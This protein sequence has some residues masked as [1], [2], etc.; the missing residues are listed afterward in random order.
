[1]HGVP[2]IR[3]WLVWS[4]ESA[5][6][7]FCFYE[8]QQS[9]VR[10]SRSPHGQRIVHEIWP[11]LRECELL[12]LRNR[13][14]FRLCARL[15]VVRSRLPEMPDLRLLLNPSGSPAAITRPSVVKTRQLCPWAT[16]HPEFRPFSFVEVCGFDD[17]CADPS[18]IVLQG[19]DVDCSQ[20]DED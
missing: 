4:S 7:T 10:E 20:H 13:W 8:D 15:R 12:L 17:H 11:D 6:E 14:K 3:R 19:P 9:H 16:L 1:M 2:D 5:F 18:L